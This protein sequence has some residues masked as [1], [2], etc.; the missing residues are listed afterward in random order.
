VYH[1]PSRA[2]D[3]PELAGRY[4]SGDLVPHA[5]PRDLF[6]A[7][8]EYLKTRAE[9][10]KSVFDQFD[11]DGSGALDEAELGHFI[12]TLMPESSPSEVRCAWAQTRRPEPLN[13]TP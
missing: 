2:G 9:R 4:Q 13:P 11:A 3:W 5:P 6:T 10:F 12:T 7:L 1:P 8:D